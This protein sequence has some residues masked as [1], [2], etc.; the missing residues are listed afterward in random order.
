MNMLNIADFR[1]APVKTDPFPYFHLE[2][3]IIP[4]YVHR[5]IDKFP[6]LKR[7]GSFNS[8]DIEKPTEFRQLIELFD[9][10]EVRSIISGKLAIDVMNKPMMATLRGYSR[11]KDGRIHTDSKTKLVTVLIYLNERWEAETG[12]LRIL[13][14]GTDM[15]DFAEEL[16]PGPGSMVAFKVTD[17]CW[18]GYRSFEGR[19]QSIQINYLTGDGVRA[20]HRLFHRLS[21]KLKS[22]FR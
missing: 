19:R 10:A 13:R 9:S 4:E 18:H 3:S 8:D 5:L 11:A 15:D 7:G 2:H 14:S 22:L 1:S 6:P 21:T 16:S 17:N 12:R 20:K